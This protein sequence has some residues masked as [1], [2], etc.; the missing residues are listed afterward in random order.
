MQRHT[1]DAAALQETARGTQDSVFTLTQF[2]RRLFAPNGT[3]IF[4]D[5]M[6]RERFGVMELIM[7]P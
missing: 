1:G 5:Q 7:E 3:H 2:A 4:S 6:G